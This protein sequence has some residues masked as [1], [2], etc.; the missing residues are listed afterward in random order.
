MNGASW[1]RAA[2][3]G[4][5][6]RAAP[7]IAPVR[8]RP[9]LSTPQGLPPRGGRS[10]PS[11]VQWGS[12]LPAAR[13]ARDEAAAAR[14]GPLFITSALAGPQGQAVGF[15][16]LGALRGGEGRPSVL[17]LR[18]GGP[19]GAG[20]AA[21]SSRLLS[22]PSGEPPQG[23]ASKKDKAGSGGELEK[24]KQEVF[25]P[26]KPWLS[27][28][29]EH[30]KHE[31][32]HYWVG[33]KLL[34]SEVRL[35]F[36]ILRQVLDGE[37]LTRR[38][39]MQLR[40]T[41]SDILKA[42]PFSVFIIVP[43]MEFAL[44]VALW[45]FPGM[46]PST[47]KHEWKVEED[48]KKQLRARIEVAKFLQSTVEHMA[49]EIRKNDKNSV[50]AEEFVHFMRRVREGDPSCTNEDIVKFSK[51]FTD[52]IT[53]DTVGRAQLVNLCRLLDITPFG[54]DAFLKYLLLQRMKAIK[55]DDVMIE[56]EGVDS[57]TIQEL[58]DALAYRG[59]RATGLSKNR[60][61]HEL[62]S[63][64]DVSLKQGLPTSLLLMSRAF[65]ITQDTSDEDAM[66]ETLQG[67]S[68]DAIESAEVNTIETDLVL[69]KQRRLEELQRQKELIEKER[70][71]KAEDTVLASVRLYLEKSA[72][73]FLLDHKADVETVFKKAKELMAK[74]GGAGAQAAVD[75]VRNEDIPQEFIVRAKCTLFEHQMVKDMQ[76]VVQERLKETKLKAD[77]SDPT[78]TDLIHAQVVHFRDGIIQKMQRLAAE[79]SAL[80]R[81]AA[82]E[83]QNATL[84]AKEEKLNQLL[85]KA[86]EPDYVVKAA[87]ESEAESK[88]VFTAATPS[89]DPSL[90][91]PLKKEDGAPVPT[92]PAGEPLTVLSKARDVLS[93]KGAFDIVTEQA[94]TD[95]AQI[96]TLLSNKSSAT[97]EEKNRI[98]DIM[99]G[100][101]QMKEA[102]KKKA[103]EGE[104][105]KP[106][107]NKAANRLEKK[108]ESMVDRLQKDL[109]NVEKS[110]GAKLHLLDADNDGVI[111]IEELQ[112]VFKRV[113]NK[114]LTKEQ[115]DVLVYHLDVNND[116]KID[117]QEAMEIYQGLTT[118]ENAMLDDK[119][120]AKA[121][122]KP[123][124]LNMPA[125]ELTDEQIALYG[126]V[127]E[128]YRWKLKEYQDQVRN[129]KERDKIREQARQA[130]V[131]AT[132]ARQA[133]ATT[134]A[135]G[136]E[137]GAEGPPSE[138][139][140]KQ[141][142]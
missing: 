44:P 34:G 80:Q 20:R 77:L 1:A 46:L 13:P 58:R 121:I 37:E 127:L 72:A 41:S 126:S 141:K 21:A 100:I 4:P 91:E 123:E 62:K 17:L 64:L 70:K 85:R 24:K 27:R 60:Y 134:V 109:N 105:A 51:L 124:I 128:E 45:L 89:T 28:M 32:Q 49:L 125:E 112:N 115:M 94:L 101:K 139:G 87:E 117:V 84:M 133:A 92:T 25:V 30:A 35:S 75:G 119:D 111:S 129:E 74:K 81:L 108:I 120:I 98:A 136:N 12:S 59:M 103:Q 2:G 90:T 73:Q 66:R 18:I 57:L 47:F 114:E 96:V 11:S 48:M 135:A 15:L 104:E 8:A 78:L 26:P 22:G 71:E 97:V 63:W 55:A 65:K 138:E 43:F 3:T 16:C 95:I 5:R 23:E 50:T 69:E 140:V 82:L 99:E 40:Q 29:W 9:R 130:E 116:G 39:L 68:Q 61:R 6:P 113:L 83:E 19:P 56:A 102:A 7:S 79:K 107:G 76:K 93:K 132:A 53:L 137:S 88:E 106:E 54:S 33:T 10:L 110:I 42:I 118:K 36:K 31:A 67:M 14:G 131:A 52:D 142:A 86:Q 38:E 122:Q